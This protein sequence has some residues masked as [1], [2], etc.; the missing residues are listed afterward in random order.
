MM[1]SDLVDVSFISPHPDGQQM[2]Y[3]FT[4]APAL[5]SSVKSDSFYMG[6]GLDDHDLYSDGS[7]SFSGLSSQS[8]SPQPHNGFPISQLPDLSLSSSMLGTNSGMISP[9]ESASSRKDSIEDEHRAEVSESHDE[10]DLEA[11]LTT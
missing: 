10:R 1:E 8:L 6:K 5:A 3:R 7:V 2:S 9:N 11:A 4:D